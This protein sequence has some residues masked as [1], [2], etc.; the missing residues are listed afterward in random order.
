MDPLHFG[1]AMV[2][3]SPMAHLSRLYTQKFPPEL[4]ELGHVVSRA[5]RF[6]CF[7]LFTTVGTALASWRS[8]SNSSSDTSFASRASTTWADYA[9][10]CLWSKGTTPCQAPARE[11]AVGMPSFCGLSSLIIS[12]SPCCLRLIW[13]LLPSPAPDME[14]FF[15]FAFAGVQ[16]ASLQPSH[17]FVQ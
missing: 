11:I 12:S 14:Q 3:V 1:Q 7:A 16:H 9:P 6:P 5:R 13:S 17:D 8:V 4:V 2:T 10:G 15:G